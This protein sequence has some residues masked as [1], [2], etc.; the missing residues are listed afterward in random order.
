MF[1]NITGIDLF[2]PN[3]GMTFANVR[4]RCSW[5]SIVLI[6]SIKMFMDITGID[7]FDQNVGKTCANVRLRCS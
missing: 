5:I 3:V 2:D 1:M 6:Y 4:L 7:F